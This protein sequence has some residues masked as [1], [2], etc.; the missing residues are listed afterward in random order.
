MF[1]S[2]EWSFHWACGHLSIRYNCNDI[3]YRCNYPLSIWRMFA[4]FLAYSCVLQSNAVLGKIRSYIKYIFKMWAKFLETSVLQLI[5]DRFFLLGLT[6][7][8]LSTV[9]IKTKQN[10]AAHLMCLIFHCNISGERTA[11]FL[12]CK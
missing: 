2:L 1:L 6:Q 7:P 4:V 8:Q 10:K 3:P 11:A 9:V 5:F 12:F